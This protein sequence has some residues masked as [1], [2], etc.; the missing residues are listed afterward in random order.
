MMT[1]TIS[2]ISKGKMEMV[3]KEVKVKV[4]VVEALVQVH[5][6]RVQLKVVQ[7]TVIVIRTR[8]QALIANFLMGLVAQVEVSAL[9]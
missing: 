4:R 9:V 7:G 1:T 2:I 8:T 6:V 5:P 3:C